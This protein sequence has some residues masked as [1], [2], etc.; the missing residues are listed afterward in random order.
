YASCP[1]VKAPD[2]SGQATDQFEEKQ[3]P[4]RGPVRGVAIARRSRPRQDSSRSVCSKGMSHIVPEE[5]AVDGTRDRRATSS[6]GQS[7][8]A[9]RTPGTCRKGSCR[10][11]G[12]ASLHPSRQQSLEHPKSYRSESRWAAACP[13][14]I[15]KY[16]RTCCF[17]ARSA[18]VRKSRPPE[19]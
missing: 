19:R 1:A 2:T 11:T 16:P 7:A 18:F 10:P 4:S 3:N 12:Q 6:R 5:I 13:S 8:S 17:Q 14:A 15:P 9:S